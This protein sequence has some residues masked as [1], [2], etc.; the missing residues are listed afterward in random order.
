MNGRYPPSRRRRAESTGLVLTFLL[1]TG[2]AGLGTSLFG[3]WKPVLVIA[4]TVAVVVFSGRRSP[5]MLL[6]GAA[7]AFAVYTTEAG[8]GDEH[9]VGGLP[10][11]KVLSVGSLCLMALFFLSKKPITAGPR[12]AKWGVAYLIWLAACSTFSGQIVLSLLRVAQAAVPFTLAVAVSR[13]SRSGQILLIGA[14]LGCAAQ[15]TLTLLHPVYVGMAGSERL[16]G[17]LVANALGVACAACVCV[18]VGLWQGQVLPPGCRW[19]AAVTVAIGA[20][21][22]FAAIGR[23]AAIAAPLGIVVSFAVGHRKQTEADLG[24]AMRRRRTILAVG[25]VVGVV[26]ALN[27]LPHLWGWFATG[28]RQISTLTGRT[29]LW[30]LLIESVLDRPLF[31]YGPGAMRFGSAALAHH[32]GDRIALGQ[33]HNSFLEALVNGGIVGGFL[34][35]GLMVSVLRHAFTLTG[36]WRP[37]AINVTVMLG[38]ISITVSNVA[39]FGMAWFLLTAVLALPNDVHDRRADGGS[40][41]VDVALGARRPLTTGATP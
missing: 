21:G 23:T 39:G 2:L 5:V 18:G 38:V 4:V 11:L 27:A 16:T 19:L 8:I 33:A 25:L 26:L 20:Y 29:T 32:I 41:G 9:A 13:R 1:F 6:T 7:W 40:D 35:V 31:G 37:V 12:P 3:G 10:S 17:L 14:T 24:T 28:N 36:R 15:V 22:I 30:R 34:W